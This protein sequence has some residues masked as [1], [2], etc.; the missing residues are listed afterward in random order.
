MCGLAN[1]VDDDADATSEDP[2]FY[3]NG[4]D[5]QGYKFVA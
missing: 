5:S 3:F 1:A 4:L 2:I